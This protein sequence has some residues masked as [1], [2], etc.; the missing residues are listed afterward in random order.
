MYDGAVEP[1][2]DADN[3]TFWYRYTT[4]EGKAF[5]P[6]PRELEAVKAGLR[7][8]PVSVLLGRRQ[9]GKTT[10]AGRLRAEHV[11]DTGEEVDLVWQAAA[12][13]WGLEVKYADAPGM[14]KSIRAALGDLPLKHVWI[15]CPGPETYRL[16]ERVTALPLSGIGQVKAHIGSSRTGATPPYSWNL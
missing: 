3:D 15:V 11:F 10:L 6:R 1:V 9:C 7:R 12:S 13:L 5:L 14:N 4:W 16:D 8:A 2:W